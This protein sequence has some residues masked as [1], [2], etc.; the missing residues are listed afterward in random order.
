M[1]KLY[2]DGDGFIFETLV[3]WARPFRQKWIVHALERLVLHARACGT[4]LSQLR[5]LILGDGAGND[6]LFLAQN[7]LMLF[8]RGPRQQDTRLRGQAISRSWASRPANQPF[9]VL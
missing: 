1:R 5:V 3:F 4:D 6:S 9:K 7:G 8:L 2:R